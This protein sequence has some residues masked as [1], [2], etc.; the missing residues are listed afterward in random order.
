M[1][2]SLRFLLLLSTISTTAAAQSDFRA[3]YIVQAA[4]DTVP[5]QVAYQ[6]AQ[7]S[8]LQCRFRPNAQATPVE[9]KPEQLRGYGFK[10]GAHYQSKALTTNPP[11]TAFFEVLASGK[12]SLLTFVDNGDRRRY[13]IQKE[14]AQVIELIQK[15]TLIENS[16][17]SST[18]STKVRSYPFRSVL[19]TSFAD[20]PA[21]QAQL[22][23]IELAESQLTKAVN[24]YNNCISGATTVEATTVEAAPRA[25]RFQSGLLFGVQRSNFVIDDSGD[26]K[27]NSAVGPMLGLGMSIRPARFNEKL[28]LRLEGLYVKQKADAEYTRSGFGIYNISK[29]QRR[30]EVD[31]TALRL[32]TMVRYAKA[33]G[34]IR[35]F[36][37]VGPQAAAHL[38]KSATITNTYNVES[39]PAPSV[40]ELEVRSGR[41]GG[42]LGGG[43]LLLTQNAGTFQLEA[44]L[45]W[46]DSQTASGRISGS[47]TTSIL[48]GYSFG[49]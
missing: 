12:V 18:Q 4:G 34:A 30:L 21:T 32:V 9:Y 35:P 42:V 29:A 20:C 7:R 31:V 5:G 46:L 37:Q 3:G 17:I 2:K 36:V 22:S 27:I 28:S 45:D 6:G 10:Q 8:A 49:K 48:L 33:A 13:Y 1:L 16:G 43:L 39:P 24:S 11:R 47:T 14:A 44:R 15:D 40:Q 41:F 26:E 25:T 19:A 23:R 38:D